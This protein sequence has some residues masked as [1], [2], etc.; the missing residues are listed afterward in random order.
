MNLIDE[1]K[2]IK[3]TRFNCLITGFNYEVVNTKSTGKGMTR[4]VDTLVREDG[5]RKDFT[6]T[7][8]LTRFKNVQKD[9]TKRD[10]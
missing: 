6:R 5:M 7:E 4:I 8:L 10:Y 2:T 3:F 1:D 9:D